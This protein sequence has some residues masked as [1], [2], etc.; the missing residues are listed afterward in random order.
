M[1]EPPV[2]QILVQKNELQIQRCD[3]KKTQTNQRH[4]IPHQHFQNHEESWQG[5]KQNRGCCLH[6]C[7]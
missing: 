7:R 3:L 1:T 6:C 2:V 4:Q 5:S